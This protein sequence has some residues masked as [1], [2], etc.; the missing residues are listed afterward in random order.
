[1]PLMLHGIHFYQE[2]H[3]N[4]CSEVCC[5][6]LVFR[7]KRLR[8]DERDLPTPNEFFRANF[9]SGK[10]RLPDYRVMKLVCL[11]CLPPIA[12][13][14]WL[15]TTQPEDEGRRGNDDGRQQEDEVCTFWAGIP[16]P[17]CL[18]PTHKIMM[19][20]VSTGNA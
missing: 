13:P 16:C 4:Q 8:D 18:Q 15:D 20:Y 12:E 3:R 19:I 9:L 10:I 2:F 17:L 1:M 5:C 7:D 14:D 6:Q 11:E